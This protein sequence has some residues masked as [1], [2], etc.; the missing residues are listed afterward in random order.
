MLIPPDKV[1]LDFQTK[2]Q[3]RMHQN[4]NSSASRVAKFQI[5]ECQR[6]W[7]LMANDFYY[8]STMNLH[9]LHICL[10]LTMITHSICYT[11][12]SFSGATHQTLKC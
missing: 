10:H 5:T 11:I 12:I 2:H 9:S 3:H 8:V 7:F 1:V 6:S 4:H